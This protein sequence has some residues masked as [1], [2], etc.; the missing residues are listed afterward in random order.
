[1]VRKSYGFKRGTRKKFESK[2]ET[3]ITKYLRKF[4]IGDTVKINID[5]S[6]PTIHHR[7][8]GKTGKI[9]EIR[10]RAYGVEIR[11]GNKLKKIFAKP[12]HLSL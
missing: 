4:N 9:V 7:F 8:Q 6:N 2:E 3:G 5:R 11:D 12:E 1:M 10:G